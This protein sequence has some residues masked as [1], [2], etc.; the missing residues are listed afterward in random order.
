MHGKLLTKAESLTSLNSLYLYPHNEIDFEITE[1]MALTI[2]NWYTEYRTSYPPEN[3]QAERRDLDY[4]LAVL[5]PV[6]MEL[7]FPPVEDSIKDSISSIGSVTDNI[8]SS[9]NRHLSH[10]NVSLMDQLLPSLK[11][12]LVNS[13]LSRLTTNR[14]MSYNY[15][16]LFSIQ[17]RPTVYIIT[18]NKLF[19]TNLLRLFQSVPKN[20]S[21]PF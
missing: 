3:H 11:G 21:S 20:T 6:I 10:A 16:R 17:N 14:I 2:R 5:L 9:V 4:A 7:V 13:K 19:T 12:Y 18:I 8:K 15:E 1:I